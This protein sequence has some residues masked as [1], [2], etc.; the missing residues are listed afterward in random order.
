MKREQ[1]FRTGTAAVLAFLLSFGG[2][3]CLATAF[4]LAC[5]LWELC[6]FC[7]LTAAVFALCFR[8]KWGS[9]AL[10][11]LLALAAG[12]LWQDGTAAQQTRNLLNVISVR[13]DRGYGCGYILP[14]SEPGIMLPLWVTAVAV[15]LVT[16]SSPALVLGVTT[17]RKVS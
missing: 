3:G 4:D 9:L 8:F 10:L 11:C 16:V 17:M 13:Y 5:D 7:F 1:W 15:I 6:G 14:G 12:Y 2:L